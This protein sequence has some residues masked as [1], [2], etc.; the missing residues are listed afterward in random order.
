MRIPTPQAIPNVMPDPLPVSEA[1]IPEN[2]QF[3]S[4]RMMVQ[5]Y[6]EIP[7]LTV[8]VANALAFNSDKKLASASV[9]QNAVQKGWT[10]M[11]TIENLGQGQIELQNQMKQVMDRMNSM[12]V[13]QVDLSGVNAAQAQMQTVLGQQ[14]Q[15]PNMQMPEL[16]DWQKAVA[17]V[18]ALFGGQN[19]G[20]VFQGL[21]QGTL[22]RNQMENQNAQANFENQFNQWRNQLQGAQTN[23]STE[24]DI[25]GI[26]QRNAQ[27]VMD[28]Q[29]G[30]DKATLDTLQK[31]YGDNN[32]L[33]AAAIRDITSN[34]RIDTQ[35]ALGLA[36]A[37][38]TGQG[39]ILR[40]I[41]DAPPEA[42]GTLYAQ[43]RATA[44]PG[45]A[46]ADLTDAE[47]D[48]IANATTIGDANVQK[49]QAQTAESKTRVKA[50]ATRMKLDE[51]R[52]AKI[53]E[54]TRWIP[55]EFEARIEER[56]ARVEI[57]KSKL[58][59]SVANF[60]QRVTEFNTRQDRES[61]KLAAKE[62]DTLIKDTD[63]IV[64]TYAEERK[65]YEAIMKNATD[66]NSAEYKQAQA[67]FNEVAKLQE[68]ALRARRQLIT[69]YN[70]T[71]PTTQQGVGSSAITDPR[72]KNM[73]GAKVQ[74][75]PPGGLP[76]VTGGNQPNSSANQPK[77]RATDANRKPN[78]VKTDANKGK[79]QKTKSG[80]EFVIE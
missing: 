78:R 59:V 34:R 60:N 20:A 63:S 73:Q 14:P 22:Q 31:M 75:V 21:Q 67:K 25:A 43:L 40:A 61:A 27:N 50:L 7:P 51:A 79:T 56:R 52:A 41:K 47:I 37:A 13:P 45:T 77:N 49:T 18:A 17:I 62:R 30:I 57:Q 44:Q 12:Q 5:A 11:Q 35:M 10:P 58:A 80:T 76:A 24:A 19:A 71:P 9:V 29:L 55:K 68:D 46:F 2:A 32:D 70:F 33:I 8:G 42:R 38:T 69:D 54:E 26:Q 16:Q 6:N 36:R 66:V 39:A 48:M 74:G 3:D 15:A 65:I 1:T 23:L 28:T 72:A 4:M 53:I 64:K